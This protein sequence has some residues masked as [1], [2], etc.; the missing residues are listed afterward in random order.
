[1]SNFKLFRK[2]E[3]YVESKQDIDNE[4]PFVDEIDEDKIPQIN[5]FP[6][7]VMRRKPSIGWTDNSQGCGSPK[8]NFKLVFK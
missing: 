1:M 7:A 8:W 3:G 2:N 4:D 5:L 6:Q